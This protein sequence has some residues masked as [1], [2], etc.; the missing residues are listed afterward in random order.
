MIYCRVANAGSGVGWGW[1]GEVLRS[2]S[3]TPFSFLFTAREMLS[4]FA[5]VTL[6]L[7]QSGPTAFETL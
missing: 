7:K 3:G 1:P 6:G 4:T 5:A 2:L